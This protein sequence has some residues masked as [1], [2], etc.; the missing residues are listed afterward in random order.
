MP[1]YVALLRGIAPSGKNMQNDKLRG[2]LESLGFTNVRSVISSGN[3]IFESP[4][5][6][7]RALESQIEAAW[8]VQLGFKSTTIVRSL[9]ELK[10]LEGRD[11]FRGYDHSP[12]TSLN[13]TFLKLPAKPGTQPPAGP[14]YIVVAAYDREICVIVDT[15]AAKTPNYMAK[16]ERIYGTQI[17]TR[18]WKTV[19][20][21]I[22]K[23]E[24]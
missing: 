24:G 17:T 22:A 19:Q 1:K 11:P 5:T 15:T 4:I 13:V 2:V 9:S 18:T 20:R 6:D 21:I 12:K 8:P 10:A 16:A 7:A 14:G 3:V 23:L